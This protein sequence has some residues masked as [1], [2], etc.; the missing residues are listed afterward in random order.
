MALNRTAKHAA[1]TGNNL[2]CCVK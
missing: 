1:R 2:Y